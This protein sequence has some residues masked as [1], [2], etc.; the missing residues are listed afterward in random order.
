MDVP[1]IGSVG[2]IYGPPCVVAYTVQPGDTW[3]SIALKYDADLAV[4]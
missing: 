4:L 1:N 2:T 3:N